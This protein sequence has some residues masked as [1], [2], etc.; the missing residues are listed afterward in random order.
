M[1]LLLQIKP[2]QFEKKL[3]TNQYNERTAALIIPLT[4]SKYINT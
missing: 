2:D 3:Y 1:P 4:V